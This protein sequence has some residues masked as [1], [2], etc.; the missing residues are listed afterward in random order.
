MKSVQFFVICCVSLLG[1]FPVAAS[2]QRFDIST[3]GKEVTDQNTGLIWRRCAEGLAWDGVSSCTGTFF[4]GTH[5]QALS[6]AV[7]QANL[8]RTLTP[9]TPWRLPN[10]KELSSI[11]DTSLS[12]PATNAV[13]PSVP[14]NAGNSK[15]WSST[16]YVYNSAN[17]WYVDFQDGYVGNTTR[18]STW[19][20]RLVR[21]RL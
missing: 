20:V 4:S 19:F 9:L 18:S 8:G 21:S 17:A 16:P 3:D 1:I 2:A 6:L 12:S 13:F 11:V 15:F 10:V 7:S 5:E 14:V